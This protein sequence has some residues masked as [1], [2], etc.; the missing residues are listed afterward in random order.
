MAK[1]VGY[2]GI[3]PEEGTFIPEEDAFAYALERCQTGTEEEVKEFREMLVDWY[4]S[5]NWIKTEGES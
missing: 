4:Y 1:E 3:G 2:L 5:G